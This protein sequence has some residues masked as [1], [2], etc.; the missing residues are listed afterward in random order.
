MSTSSAAAPSSLAQAIE[1]MTVKQ[2]ARAQE[3]ARR[4]KALEQESTRGR[5]RT[6][7]ETRSEIL[8]QKG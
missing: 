4:T 5:R 8:G 7:R 2:H 6:W 1:R 3:L